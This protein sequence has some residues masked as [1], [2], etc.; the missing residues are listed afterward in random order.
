MAANPRI[1]GVIEF[2]I[3][4]RRRQA[5]GEFTY[6]LGALKR[7]SIIGADEV[8]GFKETVQPAFIEGSI[9]DEET[10]DIKNDLLNLTNDTISLKLNNNKRVVLRNAYYT[11]D[12]SVTSEEGEIEVRF[13]SQGAEEI[14]V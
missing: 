14:G 8:H 6:N 2:N 9:T 1:A 7:E 12:G 3:N 10:L 4:G 13:E 5:K 11:A